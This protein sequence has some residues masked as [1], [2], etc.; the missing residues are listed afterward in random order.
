MLC[1][2]LLV[3]LMCTIPSMQRCSIPGCL[4][5]RCDIKGA[6]YCTGHHATKYSEPPTLDDFLRN[7]EHTRLFQDYVIAHHNRNLLE[8]VLKVSA[9]KSISSRD[10]RRTRAQPLFDTYIDT[11]SDQCV[12]VSEPVV[13]E[14]REGMSSGRLSL[15]NEARVRFICSSLARRAIP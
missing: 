5:P 12:H 1:R 8:F 4:L 7:T 13:K 10:T 2:R 9:F 14:I 11:S 6:Q 15:F 3:P